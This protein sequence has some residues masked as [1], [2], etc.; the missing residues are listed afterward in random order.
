M[1][2]RSGE[3]GPLAVIVPGSEELVGIAGKVDGSKSSIDAVVKRW[4]GTADK[5]QEHTFA[6]GSAV[7]TVNAAWQGA[8]ADAFGDYMVKYGKAG[9]ALNDALYACASSLTRAAG[10]LD[11]AETNV[12]TL[13]D[14]LVSTWNT[15]CAENPRS[16]A[17]QLAQGISASVGR[18][19]SDAREQLKKA[20]EAVTQAVKDL[21]KHLSE[22]AITFRDIPAPGEGRFTPEPSK[23]LDWER[24]PGYGQDSRGAAQQTDGGGGFG[25]YGPSGPPPPGGGPAPTGRLKEWIDEA[26]RI[27]HERDPE[28]YPLE[29]MNP[30]DIYMIIKHESGGNPNAINTWDSNA[31]AG[32]PSKGLMQTIDPTFTSALDRAFG[33]N[34]QDF[35][36]GNASI[37]HPVDNIVAGVAYA[38]GRY[39]SV[40]EV[41]GVVGMKTGTGY[42]GY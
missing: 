11:A 7:T 12:R 4:T 3:R 40:S 36:P 26:I 41:P 15:Y 37:Y 2:D 18:A 33:G 16:T 32:H 25:G 13:V 8:A 6:L 21:K 34:P 14:N 1:T 17:D 19:T 31:A 5:V 38:V 30:N 39:G 22:R 24:V 27:L 42:R 35:L 20:D 9:D 10:V 23:P 29:K 28:K